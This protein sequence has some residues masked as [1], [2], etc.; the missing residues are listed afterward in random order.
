MFP[1]SLPS[2]TYFIDR[3]SDDEQL[4]SLKEQLS[5]IDNTEQLRV[6]YI[7]ALAVIEK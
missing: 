6:I 7:K 4:A 1:A 2:L 3:Y 5:N